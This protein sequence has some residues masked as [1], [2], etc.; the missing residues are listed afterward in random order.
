[1]P[2]K[3]GEKRGEKMGSKVYA[4]WNPKIGQTPGTWSLWRVGTGP[5]RAEGQGF[6]TIKEAKDWAKEWRHEVVEV[7]SRLSRRTE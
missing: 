4:V 7:K 3:E 6:K 2:A 5:G 1:M